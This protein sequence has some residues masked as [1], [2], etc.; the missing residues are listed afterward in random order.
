MVLNTI[1]RKRLIKNKS[2]RQRSVAGDDHVWV[3]RILLYN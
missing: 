3:G 2:A 1:G